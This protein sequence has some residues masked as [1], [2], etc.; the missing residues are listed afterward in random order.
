VTSDA[1]LAASRVGERF[2]YRPAR[3]VM[4][5]ETN[6]TVVWL[7]PYDVI[8]KVGKRRHSPETLAREHAVASVLRRF[9]SPCAGPVAGAYPTTDEETGFTVTL[10]E[11]LDHDPKGLPAPEVIGHSLLE[12]HRGLARYD[13]DLPSLQ[14]SLEMARATLADDEQ[15]SA[16]PEPDRNLLRAE[17][18]RLREGVEV[19]GYSEQPLH[20]EAH[21]RNVLAT[22]NGLRWI[23]SEGVCLGPLEWDLAFLPSD[24]VKAFP[25]VDLA[26]LEMLRTLN[27]ARVATWC[28]AGY[29]F[30]E[31]RWHAEHHLEEVRRA[32]KERFRAI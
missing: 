29:E 12:L 13:G 1:V 25:S 27:S 20:G 8:A 31:L 10:W 19:H 15:M 30:V 6:N 24:A 3:P 32:R 23:D 14:F 2:D 18:D 21:D 22:P 5:Q 9:D 17:Y 7:R 26:L 16:L 28:W 4:I 11:R